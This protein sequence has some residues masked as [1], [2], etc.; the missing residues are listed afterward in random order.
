MAHPGWK[1]TTVS[2]IT[3]H[4]INIVLHLDSYS[5]E[6]HKELCPKRKQLQNDN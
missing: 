1:A 3:I 4:K 6:K 2:I 5:V